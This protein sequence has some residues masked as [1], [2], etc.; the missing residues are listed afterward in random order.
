MIGR[1][2][3]DRAVIIALAVVAGGTLVLPWETT[4]DPVYLVDGSVVTRTYGGLATGFELLAVYQLVGVLFAAI[5]T[6]LMAVVL[7]ARVAWACAVTG[8]VATVVAFGSFLDLGAAA[9]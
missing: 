5:V 6:V 1:N 8:V 7:P 4:G 3:W 9:G 2:W